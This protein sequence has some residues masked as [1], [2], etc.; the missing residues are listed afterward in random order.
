MLSL[1]APTLDDGLVDAL[2]WRSEEVVAAEALADDAAAVIAALTASIIDSLPAFETPGLPSTL[3]EPV[4]PVERLPAQ[5]ELTPRAHARKTVRPWEAQALPLALRLPGF[6][7]SPRV[8][9]GRLQLPPLP[10]LPPPSPVRILPARRHVSAAAV[11]IECHMLANASYDIKMRHIEATRHVEATLRPPSHRASRSQAASA[12][13]S[14]RPEPEAPPGVQIPELGPALIIEA[15]P[16]SMAVDGHG[17]RALSRRP[18]P[19]PKGVPQAYVSLRLP[20]KLRRDL[21]DLREDPA[22][23]MLFEARIAMVLAELALKPA[24]PLPPRARDFQSSPRALAYASVAARA[25]QPFLPTLAPPSHIRRRSVLVPAAAEAAVE[26]AAKAAEAPAAALASS[27]SPPPP[28]R[29]AIARDDA[30]PS[31]RGASDSPRAMQPQV[32]SHS[33]R[34][35]H[36]PVSDKDT[37]AYLQEVHAAEAA[38][39]PRA[40][41]QAPQEQRVSTVQEPWPT[42]RPRPSLAELNSH[43]ERKKEIAC[44]LKALRG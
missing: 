34:T 13:P 18:V 8:Q 15:P 7:L 33:P 37:A 19:Q 35:M 2:I 22:A 11:S 36:P 5:Q 39:A 23:M 9:E 38:V 29:V 16:S 25:A 14:W 4:E 32:S 20:A 27:S 44:T 43:R 30:V 41:N 3:D 42:I 17:S 10:P 24:P 40:T 26:A 1:T 28:K 12:E 6:Q 31:G 21:D